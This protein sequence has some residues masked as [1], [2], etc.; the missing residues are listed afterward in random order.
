MVLKVLIPKSAIKRYLNKIRAITAPSTHKDSVAAK[1]TALNR[2]TRGWCQYYSITSSTSQVCNKLNHELFWEMAH[3]LGRKY[4]LDMPAVMQ[5]F[6]KENTFGSNAR[7]LRMPDEIKTRKRLVRAWHHPYTDQEKVQE[8]K[9]R[10]KRASLFSYD[11][12]WNGH[13]DRQGGW[14]LREAMLRINGT[15]CA[16]QGPD[17]MSRGK[18]LHPSEG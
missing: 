12:T 14:D 8:E 9:E 7:M 17:C 16:I 2:L 5:K 6:R 4:V 18:P 3:W 1:I 11:Q 13:E 10:I 15:I